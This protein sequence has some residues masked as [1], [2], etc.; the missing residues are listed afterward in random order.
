MYMYTT[1][2]LTHMYIDI[3]IPH[4]HIPVHLPSTPPNHHHHHHRYAETW[5]A[6]I[7]ME[8]RAGNIREARALFRR[9]LGGKALEE[10]GTGVVCAAW[11]RFEREEGRYVFVGGMLGGC[12]MYLLCVCVC[13]CV[14]VKYNQDTSCGQQ[15][16]PTLPPTHTPSHPPSPH[17]PSPNTPSH[18]PS[19]TPVWRNT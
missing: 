11:L 19:H 13:V 17:P 1:Y 3:Y 10:Q 16:P 5:A 8:R 12:W 9:V 2:T 14:C 7:D 18:T 4:I 6:Y 15:H